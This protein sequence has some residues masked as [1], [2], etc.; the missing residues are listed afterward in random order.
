MR[1]RDES[2]AP[3]LIEP[4]VAWRVWHAVESDGELL[5]SSV[6]RR[7]T[8][9]RGRALEAVCDRA[10]FPVISRRS[11]HVAPAERC[12]C[13]IYAADAHTAQEYLPGSSHPPSAYPVI[14]RVRLWGE[15]VECD[16]GW[17]ASRAYP[18]RIYVPRLEG[19]RVDRARLATSLG[20]YGVPVTV[21][22]AATR[23]GVVDRVAPAIDAR[24]RSVVET[25]DVS[26]LLPETWR[27][28]SR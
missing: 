9:P 13:G 3:D 2:R 11:R 5:L 12:Q 8:W 26:L 7:V 23:D 20:A 21:L 17:R 4:V 28:W 19:S 25:W 14:G 10:R 16:R 6:Y 22:D 27:F 15:V 18:D 1:D 24:T